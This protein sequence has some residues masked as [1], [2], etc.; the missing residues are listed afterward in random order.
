M[1]LRITF[2]MNYSQSYKDRKTGKRK[3]SYSIAMYL[4]DRCMGSSDQSR[5]K[6]QQYSRLDKP[7]MN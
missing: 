5:V 1:S 4:H 3:Q 6:I 2:T 7:A